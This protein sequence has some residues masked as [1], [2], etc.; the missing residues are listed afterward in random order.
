MKDMCV[1]DFSGEHITVPLDLVSHVSRKHSEVL[2]FL[3]TG[4]EGFFE[5]LCD[6]LEKPDEAYVDSS[7]AKYFL[8]RLIPAPLYLNVIVDEGIV[9][10]AY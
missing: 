5:L 9:R 7:G 3:C 6:I 8:K 4:E 10:T 2:S 1:K